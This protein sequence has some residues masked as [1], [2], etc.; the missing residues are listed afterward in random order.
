MY[1]L[2]HTSMSYD[3]IGERTIPQLE[4]LMKR[5]GRH[6]EL[7]TGIPGLFTGATTEPSSSTTPDREHTVDEGQQFAALFSGLG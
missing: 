2:A 5:L 4:A 7:K 1:L 6:I 3:D